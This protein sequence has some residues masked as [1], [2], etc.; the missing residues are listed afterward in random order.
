MCVCVGRGSKYFKVFSDWL[1]LTADLYG[2]VLI[3]GPLWTQF[4]DVV[5]LERIAILL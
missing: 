1:T 4:D 2:I 5:V 3:A